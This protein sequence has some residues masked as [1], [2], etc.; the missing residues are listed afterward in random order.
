MGQHYDRIKDACRLGR[1][2][3]GEKRGTG[4]QYTAC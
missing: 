4:E 3:Q 2:W 1:E